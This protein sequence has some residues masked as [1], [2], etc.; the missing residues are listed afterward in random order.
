MDAANSF[1]QVPTNSPFKKY[2]VALR[3]CNLSKLANMLNRWFDDT[4]VSGKDS[5][6]R[7]TRKDSRLLLLNFMSLISVVEPDAQPGRSRTKLHVLAYMF[8]CLRDC[9][10]LSNR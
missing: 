2:S 7:F 9:V 10:S 6:Y 4:K 1:S 5:D 3:S 8:I